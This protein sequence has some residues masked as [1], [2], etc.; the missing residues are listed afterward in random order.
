MVGDMVA[1]K[2]GGDDVPRGSSRFKWTTDGKIYKIC[3]VLGENTYKLESLTGMDEPVSEFV[4]NRFS[5]DR[6]V[7]LDM[8]ELEST[9][10]GSPRIL[11][12]YD[13]EVGDWVRGRVEKLA[14]DGRTMIRFDSSSKLAQWIDLTRC[15]Y[16]WL[17][18]VPG[19]TDQGA[20]AVADS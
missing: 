17:T 7:K 5:A 12:I 9:Q 19:V 14:V 16:R 3:G 15:R 11:E 10:E 20:P 6:L 2:R 18:E 13:E 1:V 8:P 4:Q